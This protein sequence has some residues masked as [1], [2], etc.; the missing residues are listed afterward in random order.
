M[1]RLAILSLSALALAA[2]S[3][4]PA[5]Q[6]SADE[7]ADRIGSGAPGA[8]ATLDPSQPDPN[9]PNFATDTPPVGVDLTQL[10]RLG[11]VGGVN[12]GPRQGGCTFMVDEQ[13]L[14]IAVGMNEPTL[15]G[16]A[17][18]RVGNQ[19]VMADAGPG[20]LAAIKGGTTF[21]GEGFTVQVA[22]AAG[23]AQSRPARVAVSD[24]TGNQQNYSGNWI[25]A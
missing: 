21:T 5:P 22:P 16:K 10:Q 15:P 17:V 25:C 9:A 14:I 3:S 19:L 1:M 20:G 2:C 7:F 24:A 11:D 6:E 18:V 12:L 13:E 23:E 8:S 4:E